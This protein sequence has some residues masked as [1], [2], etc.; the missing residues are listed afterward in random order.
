M[1]KGK[2]GG[3]TFLFGENLQLERS[4][5]RQGIRESLDESVDQRLVVGGEHAHVIARLVAQIT[6]EVVAD[7]KTHVDWL[8]TVVVVIKSF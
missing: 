6:V 2:D 8:W 1:M 3:G 7:S 4:G 5:V